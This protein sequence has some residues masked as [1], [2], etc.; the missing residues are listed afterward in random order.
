MRLSSWFL[1]PSSS[2]WGLLPALPANGA[3]GITVTPKANV[4]NAAVLDSPP[5]IAL[6]LF[7]GASLAPTHPPW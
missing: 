3:G 2:F 4:P 1:L 6:Q 7:P 5:S